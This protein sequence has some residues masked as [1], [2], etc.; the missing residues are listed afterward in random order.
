[1]NSLIIMVRVVEYSTEM[2]ALCQGPGSQ[3]DVLLDTE[4]CCRALLKC[5]RESV[6]NFPFR[7]HSC[8]M[9]LSVFDISESVE[10]GVTL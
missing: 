9:F 8:D 1:M 5:V 7:G 4:Q 6:N 3:R 2:H 10:L